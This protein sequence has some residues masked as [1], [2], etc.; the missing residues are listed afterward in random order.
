[1][2]PEPANGEVA[3]EESEAVVCLKV[4]VEK[5]SVELVAEH[6]S[7]TRNEHSFRVI[8]S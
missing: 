4:I 3:V 8:A 5:T 2:A 1:M 6:L 7:P